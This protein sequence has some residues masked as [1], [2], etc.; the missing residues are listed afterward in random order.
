MSEP[1][2]PACLTAHT[3]TGTTPICV[4]HAQ[5]LQ[6][7]YRMLGTHVNFTQ[8]EPDAQCENCVNEAARKP[9]ADTDV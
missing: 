4:E 3:P 9:K 7:L 1:T 6:A 5:K 2:Y 8:V